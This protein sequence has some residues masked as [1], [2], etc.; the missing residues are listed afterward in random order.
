[1]LDFSFQAFCF[2]MLVAVA[3]GYYGCAIGKARQ[4]AKTEIEKLKFKH[5]SMHDLVKE[6]AKM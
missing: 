2:P 1:M 3:Q 4:S 5:L 6:V